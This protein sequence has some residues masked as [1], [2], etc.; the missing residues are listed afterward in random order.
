MELLIVTYHY[1]DDP[2]KY[3]AGIYPIAPEVFKIQMERISRTRKFISEEDLLA[4]TS[5]EQSFVGN[6]CLVTFDDGLASQARF[7]APILEKLNIPA[8]FFVTTQPYTNGKAATVHKIH[9]L[10]SRVPA[11]TLK[12]EAEDS[13]KKLTGEVL[14][15]STENLAK[16]GEWYIYDDLVT[17]RLKYLLNHHLDSEKTDH[18]VDDLF[19]RHHKE[20]EAAFAEELYFSKDDLTMIKDNPLFAVGLHTHT[21]LNIHSAPE[22]V[23][24]SDIMAN[25]SYLS[26]HF[27][28]TIRGISYP[29]GMISETEYEK[30]VVTTAKE[31][32]LLYGVTTVK[33]INSDLGRPFFLKRLNPNDLTSKDWLV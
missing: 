28:M 24:K 23:V 31:L 14:N 21:H 11:E 30:K 7:A 10:L 19:V 22:S 9:Y 18:I 25:Y 2:R 17:A 33:G 27:G 29:Y 4:L 8:I 32:G 3:K 16:A 15:W 5:G 13:Y 12:A 6:L 26:E 1:I 20:G